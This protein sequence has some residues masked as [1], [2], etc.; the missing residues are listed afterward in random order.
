MGSSPS[1]QSTDYEEIDL[2]GLSPANTNGDLFADSEEGE[3]ASGKED[4]VFDTPSDSENAEEENDVQ[5]EDDVVEAEQQEQED[6]EEEEVEEGGEVG[7]EGVEKG[8]VDSDIVE[9]PSFLVETDA[10]AL[11]NLTITF[12]NESIK[13][14][15]DQRTRLESDQEEAEGEAEEEELGEGEDDELK[16]AVDPT[17]EGPASS[18]GSDIV[19]QEVED[20]GGEFLTNDTRI[21]FTESEGE[22]DSTESAPQSKPKQHVSVNGSLA[23]GSVQTASTSTVVAT[24]DYSLEVKP[25]QKIPISKKPGKLIR[26]LS[27]K[28]MEQKE[29]QNESGDSKKSTLSESKK[30]PVVSKGCSLSKSKPGNQNG[31]LKEMSSS[32]LADSS[33]VG[34]RGSPRSQPKPVKTSVVKQSTSK[35]DREQSN[36]TTVKNSKVA[37]KSITKEA[38]NGLKNGSKA[39]LNKDEPTRLCSTVCLAKETPKKSPLSQGREQP[40]PQME[41]TLDNDADR[42]SIGTSDEDS[43]FEQSEEQPVIKSKAWGH[44]IL[45]VRRDSR[46]RSSPPRDRSNSPRRSWTHEREQGKFRSVDTPRVRDRSRLRGRSRSRDRYESHGRTRHKRSPVRRDR[47]RDRLHERNRGRRS[48]RSPVDRRRNRSRSQSR[49]KKTPYRDGTG[50]REG[51]R[52]R[53]RSWSYDS[54]SR[55]SKLKRVPRSAVTSTM[56]KLS[57]G[58]MKSKVKHSSTSLKEGGKDKKLSI[59]K[60]HKSDP[61]KKV[62]AVVVVNE[63]KESVRHSPSS[64]SHR[65]LPERKKEEGMSLLIL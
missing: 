5:S 61:P 37:P 11:D 10:G 42:L 17:D 54:K 63:Q 4:T 3:N 49:E 51:S 1:S 39:K 55:E 14:E 52:G 2:S 45:A 16:I 34:S 25:T 18:N 60:D 21:V 9:D 62:K 65:G 36:L 47:S 7:D 30:G 13:N 27:S 29:W 33:K 57:E 6:P 56:H 48:Q 35:D 44:K 38:N 20:T 50:S 64:K 24:K 40:S 26:E 41:N 19:S 28:N 22:E 12:A 46:E 43:E 8:D 32:K 53:K 23:E 15:Y 31:N 59:E 58:R